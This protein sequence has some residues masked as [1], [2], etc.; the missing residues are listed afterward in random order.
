MTWYYS[1]T[2]K[3]KIKM[4]DD[5]ISKKLK[6]IQR[7]KLKNKK[8]GRELSSGQGGLFLLRKHASYTLSTRGLFG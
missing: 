1:R 8:R 3:T 4:I 2:K 6:I 7:N 5:L